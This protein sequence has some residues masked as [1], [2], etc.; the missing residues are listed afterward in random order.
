MAEALPRNP[1]KYWLAGGDTLMKASQR[2]LDKASR[3]FSMRSRI[4]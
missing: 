2:M 4:I 1:D 3:T